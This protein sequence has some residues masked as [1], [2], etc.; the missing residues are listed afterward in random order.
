MTGSTSYRCSRLSYSMMKP[1]SPSLTQ[2]RRQRLEGDLDMYVKRFHEKALD[3]YDPVAKEVLV[4]VCL[5][6]V[7]EEYRIFLE[8]LSFSY[9][10]QV[11]GSGFWH[12]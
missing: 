6:G 10:F 4:N 5:H 9:F 7:F 11:N 2:S 12:Q 1:I 8:N 3:Y